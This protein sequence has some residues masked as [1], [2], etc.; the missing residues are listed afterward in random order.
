MFRLGDII[1][2]ERTTDRVAVITKNIQYDVIFQSEEITINDICN[3]RCA[4]LSLAYYANSLLA[5]FALEA[6]AG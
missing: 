6:Y 2:T 1:P 5:T 3:V 4:R